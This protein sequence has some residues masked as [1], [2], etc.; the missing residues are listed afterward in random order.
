MPSL[1]FK[2]ISDQIKQRNF[3]PIYL[4]HGEEPFFIDTLASLFEST[5][6]Q[7]HEKSFNQ[8]ILYG[9]DVQTNQIR[10][11]ATR[12]PMMA[13]YQLIIIKEAQGLAKIEELESYVS[14]P[15]ATTILVLCHK[16][17]KLDLR[18]KL[19]QTI[20]KT[21]IEFESKKI[22]DDKIPGWIIEQLKNDKI[23]IKPEA[24]T[25]IAD[26]LGND[27]SKISNELGKLR[28][29][30]TEGKE[31]DLDDV[32]KHIGIN[33]EYNIFEF[34]KA[35]GQKNKLKAYKMAFYFMEN[36]KSNPFIA[37]N[38]M[39]FSYFTKLYRLH[40][41]KETNNNNLARA[42]GIPSPFFVPEYKAAARNYPPKKIEQ[43]FHHLKEYDLK[44]KGVNIDKLNNEALLKEMIF[45]IIG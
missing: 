35:I 7:E 3:Q 31:I 18:K 5:V 32:H 12:Y 10:D 19:G 45:K 42:I 44:S 24:A 2:E 6:L 34:Q 26:H 15:V 17:K 43:I 29:H 23:K 11:A 40:A 1:S 9:A 30:I 4:L 41:T 8:T 22:Y 20:K 16:H 13:P 37:I 33:R 25:L 39:L 14:N 36:P 21:G 28:L 27:L 38:V